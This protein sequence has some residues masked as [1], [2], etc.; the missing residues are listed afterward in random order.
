MANSSLSHRQTMKPCPFC[1]EKPTGTFYGEHGVT[2]VNCPNRE[3][4]A[5]C[6]QVSVQQW[7]ARVENPDDMA[8]L[9]LR[10]ISRAQWLKIQFTVDLTS[11]GWEVH[12]GDE[13]GMIVSPASDVTHVCGINSRMTDIEVEREKQARL[14][15]IRQDLYERLTP[16]EREAVGL[17][18]P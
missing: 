12:F 8:M 10:L 14:T 6:R 15:T 17:T 13:V 7:N 2:A 3:C 4:V 1:G 16:E 9:A 11:T 5:F 18:K